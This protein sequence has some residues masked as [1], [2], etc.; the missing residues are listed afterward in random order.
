MHQIVFETVDRSGRSCGTS[1]PVLRDI[2]VRL[3]RGVLGTRQEHALTPRVLAR[4]V[5]VHL[6]AK[7]SKVSSQYVHSVLFR[8]RMHPQFMASGSSLT[9]S[10]TH[11]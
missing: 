5:P 7:W 9:H 6:L 1:V 4:G 10:L 2:F 3:G 11:E 8:R